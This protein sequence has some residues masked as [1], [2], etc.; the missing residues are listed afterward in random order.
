MKFHWDKKYLYWGI[1]AFL[2]ICAS[3]CFYYLLFHS[4]N[5]WSGVRSFFTI[6]MPIVDGF[7]LAYLLS[8]LLNGVEKRIVYPCY[9]LITNV[10]RKNASKKAKEM[11]RK[12]GIVITVFIAFLLMYIFFSILIPQLIYSIQSIIQQFPTYLENLNDW[13]VKIFVNNPQLEITVNDLFVRY[14]AKVE[15]WLAYHVVPQA[16]SLIKMISTGLIGSVIGAAKAMWN[17]VIGFIISIYLLNSKE[18]FA[19]QGKKIIYAFFS[20]E[21]ANVFVSNVRF[22]H[23]TFIDFIGGKIIDSIIIGIICYFATNLIGTPY[24]ML[25]SVIVGVTNIIPFFGPF[26]GA[27]PSALLIL[28]VDPLQ[29]LYFVIFVFLLQQFD[30]N[31]LGPK[32][33]GESTGLSSFWVIFSITLFSGLFGVFGMII[34]VPVFAVIYAGIRA[35]IHS[36]LEEKSLPVDTSNYV[37]V[38]TIEEGG[39]F[40]TYEPRKRKKKRNQEASSSTAEE[41]NDTNNQIG[42]GDSWLLLKHKKKQEN[43]EEK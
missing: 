8:P 5:L 31:I 10:E 2:V 38:R 20:T 27:I 1:T 25:I 21:T 28:M 33:L 40:E 9:T 34:G 23:R 16:N 12:V 4:H 43:N 13:I 11:L 24:P 19:G 36:R 37:S 41:N 30:G 6:I 26:I 39:T 17:L 3:I 14:S 15:E 18:T 22:I 42:F 32:I 35:V 7:V 29:C